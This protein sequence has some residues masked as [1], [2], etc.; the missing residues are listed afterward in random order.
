VVFLGAVFIYALV[1]LGF[2][3]AILILSMLMN[4]EVVLLFFWVVGSA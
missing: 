2:S 3:T 1:G 4:D